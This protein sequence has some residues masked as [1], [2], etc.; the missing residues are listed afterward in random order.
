LYSVREIK[1]QRQ[2]EGDQNREKEIESSRTETEKRD[3]STHRMKMTT[4]GD[5]IKDSS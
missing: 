5:D 2:K 4:A 1:E 3:G